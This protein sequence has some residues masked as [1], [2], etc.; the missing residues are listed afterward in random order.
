MSFESVTQPEKW[1]KKRKKGEKKGEKRGGK[2]CTAESRKPCVPTGTG[3]R[4]SPLFF[5][6]SARK[7]RQRRSGTVVDAALPRPRKSVDSD[8]VVGVCRI[9]LLFDSR[10]S[11]RKARVALASR[12]NTCCGARPDLLPSALPVPRSGLV[13]SELLLLQRHSDKVAEGHVR[14]QKGVLG[15]R[16]ACSVAEGHV[17]WQK[18]ML[19]LI[20]QPQ[21]RFVF[22]DA[23]MWWRSESP[24]LRCQLSAIETV[25]CAPPQQ[26]NGSSVQKILCRTRPF[27]RLADG[28]GGRQ[29]GRGLGRDATEISQICNSNLVWFELQLPLEN[30][31]AVMR[32]GAKD[33]AVNADVYVSFQGLIVLL[34]LPLRGWR[35]EG[36]DVTEERERVAALP[37]G[38]RKHPQRFLTTAAGWGFSANS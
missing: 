1:R 10:N 11:K 12:L 14:W 21:C 16:R 13:P 22:L 3:V 18:I 29:S 6:D 15:G 23:T 4:R 31:R 20:I 26:P 37:A 25:N 33:C 8:L 2:P 17:R 36:G 28:A 32:R 9:P 19:G 27:I 35:L 34:C 5:L 30:W 7:R 24:L 38:G